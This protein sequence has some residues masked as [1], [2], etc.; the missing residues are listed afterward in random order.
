MELSNDGDD[1]GDEN[2]WK[3]SELDRE[4]RIEIWCSTEI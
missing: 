2:M 4:T 3:C 1:G